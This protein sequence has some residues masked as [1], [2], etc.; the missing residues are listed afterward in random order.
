MLRRHRRTLAAIFASPTRANLVFGDV[1]AM[2]RALGADVDEGRAGSRV[3]VTLGDRRM[4]LHKP[5]PRKEVKK[6]VVEDVRAF[7]AEADVTPRS[8]TEED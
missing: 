1:L 5:H 7:L 3:R 2:L 8:V 6:Y 4:T